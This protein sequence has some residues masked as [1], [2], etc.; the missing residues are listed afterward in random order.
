MAYRTVN[1]IFCV[2]HGSSNPSD[3]EWKAYLDYYLANERECL[4]TLVVT[5]GG[6]PNA[7]QRAETAKLIQSAPTR[8][9]I[10]SSSTFVRGV[11]TA[12]SWFNKRVQAFS[13]T[14]MDRALSYLEVT[15]NLA[16]L[17]T[18]ELKT[19]QATITH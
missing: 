18:A 8:V 16:R 11:A 17:I 6:G 13:D 19:L 2:A 15:D 7:K 9:A 14:E 4:R 3:E 1:G 5:D 10:V 12:L